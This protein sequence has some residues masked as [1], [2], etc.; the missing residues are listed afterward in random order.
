[1]EYSQVRNKGQT[2]I[3]RRDLRK[4]SFC[5]LASTRV[6]KNETCYVKFEKGTMA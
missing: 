5:E 2:N 6:G 1:M 4:S 3:V